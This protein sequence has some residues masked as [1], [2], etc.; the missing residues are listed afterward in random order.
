MD[1]DEEVSVFRSLCIAKHLMSSMR[2]VAFE[3]AGRQGCIAV[4][5]EVGPAAMVVEQWRFISPSQ[6]RPAETLLSTGQ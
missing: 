2:V 1:G 4:M 5:Q 6:A 3:Q